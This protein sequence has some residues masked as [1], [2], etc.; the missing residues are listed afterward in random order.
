VLR[1]LAPRPA[2]RRAYH[3]ACL[4]TPGHYRRISPGIPAAEEHVR[5]R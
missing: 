5:W 1:G 2:R 4:A 3:P